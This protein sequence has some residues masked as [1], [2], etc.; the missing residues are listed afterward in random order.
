MVLAAARA[1]TNS[2]PAIDRPT[3]FKAKDRMVDYNITKAYRIA[4]R[5]FPFTHPRLGQAEA[6][7]LRQFQTGSLP[8]RH[9]AP[10]VPRDIPDRQVQV[11]WRETGDHTYIL[12]DCI[13]HP[14]A[15]RSRAIRSRLDAAAK[16]H[17]QEEQLWAVQQVLGAL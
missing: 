4:R 16:S 7:L 13:K 12:W 10:H 11:C 8:S 9:C 6:V 2:A 5:T 17:D 14:E 1:L 3:W 15:A